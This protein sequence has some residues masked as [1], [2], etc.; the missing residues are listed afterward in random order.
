[1]QNLETHDFW[2]MNCNNMLILDR[3]R[4]KRRGKGQEML[5]LALKQ[6]RELQFAITI[7]VSIPLFI[8][9]HLFISNF[10]LLV[11][12]EFGPSFAW[13]GNLA[14]L[15]AKLRGIDYGGDG[16]MVVGAVIAPEVIVHLTA[17]DTHIDYDA[18]LLIVQS[19]KARQYGDLVS[20]TKLFIKD[21]Q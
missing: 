4:H 17:A 12:E 21:A 6:Q 19:L 5:K 16:G 15:K 11:R 8:Y 20:R 2:N 13:I 9:W 14:A 10:P 18:A 3:E 7:D 1:M